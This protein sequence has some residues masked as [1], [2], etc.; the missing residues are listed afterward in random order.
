MKAA[1]DE[2]NSVSNPT[3]EL[4]A[5]SAKSNQSK[6]SANDAPIQRQHTSTY[7]KDYIQVSNSVVGILLALTVFL[8]ATG[9][10][11][12]EKLGDQSDYYNYEKEINALKKQISDNKAEISLL[13]KQLQQSQQLSS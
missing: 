2:L 11:V 8:I 10:C 13:T 6:R 7:C 1:R 4:A 9:T 3:D 12:A 5:A